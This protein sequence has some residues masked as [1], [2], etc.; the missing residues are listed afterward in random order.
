MF[1]LLGK[2]GISFYKELKRISIQKR[3][4]SFDSFGIFTTESFQWIHEMC[5][6]D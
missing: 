1:S 6:L 4:S 5:I 2:R 3:S